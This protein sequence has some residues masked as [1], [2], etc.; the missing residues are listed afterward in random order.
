MSAVV[1]KV[2]RRQAF[3]QQM[4]VFIRA[5][6]ATQSDSASLENL[7]NLAD[8]ALASKNERKYIQVGVA[9][10]QVSESIHW[11]IRRFFPT[12]KEINNSAAKKNTIAICSPLKIVKAN[13]QFYQT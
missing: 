9:E 13:K 8:W 12:T 4:P 7:A 1:G 11:N 6:L 2:V 10:I 5:D 3:I